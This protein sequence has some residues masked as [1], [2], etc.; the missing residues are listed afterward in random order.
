MEIS[1]YLYFTRVGKKGEIE[2]SGEP[3]CTI[4]SKSILDV[5]IKEFVLFC[6]DGIRL[7]NT[8]EYNK[9]SFDYKGK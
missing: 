7:Y 5:G 3:Y 6:K 2:T 8:G 9:I 4:C 1:S